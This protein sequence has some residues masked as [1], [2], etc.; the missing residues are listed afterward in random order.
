M[1]GKALHTCSVSVGH[2]AMETRGAARGDAQHARSR[3]PAATPSRRPAA[4]D[5]CAFDG[6]GP[7][8][9]NSP[10]ADSLSQEHFLLPLEGPV[11]RPEAVVAAV[12]PATKQKTRVRASDAGTARSQH[13]R[14]LHRLQLLP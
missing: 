13:L 8:P 2:A 7:G 12:L 4:E 11:G 6:G 3:R 10:H 9:P 5:A 1:T 14:F